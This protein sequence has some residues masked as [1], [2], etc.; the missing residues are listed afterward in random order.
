MNQITNPFDKEAN[1]YLRTLKKIQN[2]EEGFI[3]SFGSKLNKLPEDIAINGPLRE[4]LL[5]L[6]ICVYSNTPLFICGKPGSSKTITVNIFFDIFRQKKAS[7]LES[8]YEFFNCLKPIKQLYYQGSEQSTD[9]G[10]ERVFKS[11]Q[12][13]QKKYKQEIPLLFFD[14]IG[15]AELSPHNPLKVLHKY[16]EYNIDDEKQQEKITALLNDR[17]N[18]KSTKISENQ[19]QRRKKEINSMSIPFVGISNWTLDVSKMNR[20]IYL[21]RPNP[22]YMDLYQT[23]LKI[24]LYEKNLN[25]QNMSHRTAID[26]SILLADTY[27]RFRES[28]FKKFT[29][30]NFHSLRDY[31]CLLKCIGANKIDFQK[32]DESID[33]ILEAIY[34]NFSGYFCPI[35]KSGNKEFLYSQQG[36]LLI[37]LMFRNIEQFKRSY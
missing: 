21:S 22:E 29:H 20:N 32:E 28:Q 33:V 37:I 24:I 15:L 16:L 8:K 1:I 17:E 31:Y 23:A 34:K 10:I 9:E 3:I 30:K 25:R 18:K 5:A 12:E 36:R 26:F 7:N 13:K 14:E 2:E 27:D 4:N 19:S 35:N 6:F 11:G